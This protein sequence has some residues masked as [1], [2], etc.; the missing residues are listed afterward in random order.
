MTVLLNEVQ[1]TALASQNQAVTAWT[2]AEKAVLKLYED[3]S[4]MAAVYTLRQKTS[5][6]AM[7]LAQTV[8]F[9]HVHVKVIDAFVTLDAKYQPKDVT[10]EVELDEAIEKVP[11]GK[12]N[13]YYTRFVEVMVMARV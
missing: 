2:D 4:K 5:A 10:P 6:G 7:V 1:Y 8:T 9:E 11:F 13:D 12:A 3:K